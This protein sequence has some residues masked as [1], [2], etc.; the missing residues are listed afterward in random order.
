M[1]PCVLRLPAPAK[2][3]L[4]LHIVGRRADGYHL[5]Q[6]VFTFLDYSDTL[7]F[8]P[9]PELCLIDSD[10]GI[11][12]ND[13]LIIAAARLLQ[14]ETGCTK[15]ALIR[16]EKKLPI[17]GGLGGGSSNA[18]TTLIGLNRMWQLGLSLD[19][20]A[21]IGLQ[22]GADVPV[23][24][25]GQTAFA[26]GVGEQLTPI[27]LPETEYF[28]LHP[29]ISVSTAEIFADPQLTR[30]HVPRT[31]ADFLAASES[32]L[33]VNACETI[34]CRQQ[35]II[36]KA[37]NWLADQAGNSRLTGTGACVF[38]AL[39]QPT[40]G[41]RIR[42]CLPPEWSGFVAKSCQISPLHRALKNLQ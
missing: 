33:F 32:A 6:T 22:L 26:E 34:S 30:D 14:Q 25:H 8:R 31:V 3:N 36:A 35:P 17:G 38:A 12:P 27:E 24:I 15:G 9:H 37:L 21:T 13:N 2:L 4:F 5:L 40:N 7:C 1:T 39:D 16:L 10:S 20:L 41:N 23:F 19:E 29:G 18:A 11:T 28:V 42:T